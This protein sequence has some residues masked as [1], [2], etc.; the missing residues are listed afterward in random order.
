MNKVEEELGN[1]LYKQNKHRIIVRFVASLELRIL[2]MEA[3]IGIVGYAFQMKVTLKKVEKMMQKCINC[4]AEMKVGR[5]EKAKFCANCN[6][7]RQID[8]AEIKKIFKDL[9]KRNSKMTP[10][11]LEMNEKFEDDPRAK[12]EQLYGKVSKV[13]DR[14]YYSPV[15]SI[16]DES[17]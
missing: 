17:M 11:E 15:S 13:P 10:E 14:S 7:E 2:L 9:K 4:G 6:Y 1:Q 8:N 3:G 12:T 16:D 5:Y